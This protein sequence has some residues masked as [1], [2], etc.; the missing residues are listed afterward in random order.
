[1]AT[2][3]VSLSQLVVKGDTVSNDTLSGLGARNG[4][5]PVDGD[6]ML[7]TAQT[8]QTT[9]GPYIA[10]S[11]A[12]D[13]IISVQTGQQY[14]VSSGTD[15]GKNFVLTTAGISPSSFNSTTGAGLT[16]LVLVGGAAAFDPAKPGTIG[17]TT[18]GLV[19]ATDYYLGTSG[20]SPTSGKL[21]LAATANAANLTI[22]AGSGSQ[23]SVGHVESTTS[24][25]GAVR[26][27]TLTLANNATGDFDN[28]SLGGSAVIASNDGTVVATVGFST[29]AVTT[30]GGL[31]FTNF[32]TTLTTASKLN[33]AASGG[34]LRLEN[35]T[36]GTL[37]LVVTITLFV[38]A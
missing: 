36:A 27:W 34:K 11:G 10:R 23:V 1:M 37:N 30:T 19:N 3:T 12:W 5:T 17:A 33:C 24:A 2:F 9:N 21:Q 29:A 35:K 4:V 18:P 13:R 38:A 6:L 15:A 25:R 8:D 16:N 14:F 31:T 20:G 32:S 28:T 7:A 22:I 26:T